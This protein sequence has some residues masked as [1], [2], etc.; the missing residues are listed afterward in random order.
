[1]TTTKC[2]KSVSKAELAASE[3][4]E[5]VVEESAETTEA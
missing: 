4:A 1:M 2:E 5:A 3:S